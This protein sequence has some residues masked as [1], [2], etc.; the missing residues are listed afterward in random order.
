MKRQWEMMC[1]RSRGVNPSS[2]GTCED[3]SEQSSKNVLDTMQENGRL[4]L[5][6]L[7]GGHRLVNDC[8][9]TFSKKNNQKRG[10]SCD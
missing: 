5:L 9:Q 8:M 2:K 7:R 10:G 1:E 3:C 6:A 4:L